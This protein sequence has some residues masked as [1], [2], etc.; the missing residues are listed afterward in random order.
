MGAPA[1]N[2]DH[3]IGYL[4]EAELK[5]LQNAHVFHLCPSETEGFGHYLVEAMGIGAGTDGAFH[6]EETVPPKLDAILQLLLTPIDKCDREKRS[7]NL[8]PF[9]LDFVC[10]I[11]I[12]SIMPIDI[13]LL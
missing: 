6:L 12:F 13:S 11:K 9:I 7:I 8:L 1:A 2:I 3:R 5:R 4:D 10:C